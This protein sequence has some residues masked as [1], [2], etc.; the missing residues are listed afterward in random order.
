MNSD[1]GLHPRAPRGSDFIAA[2]PSGS[3]YSRCSS[4]NMFLWARPTWRSGI[5][6]QGCGRPRPQQ[7]RH[8]PARRTFSRP[9]HS[10]ALLRPRTGAFRQTRTRSTASACLGMSKATARPGRRGFRCGAC[11]C[12]QRLRHLGRGGSRTRSVARNKNKNRARL[13]PPVGGLRE[14]RI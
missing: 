11:R 10:S 12:A 9:H 7:I 5:C 3:V 14:T 13:S 8:A 4:M 1:E 6:L 2:R